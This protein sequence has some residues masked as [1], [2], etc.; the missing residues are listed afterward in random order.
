[1]MNKKIALP[2]FLALAVVV[3]IM[4]GIKINREARF[5]K[6]FSFNYHPDK[7]QTILNFISANYVDTIDANKIGEEGYEQIMQQL[8]PH[9]NYI[10]AKDYNMVNEPLQ[11]NFKGVGIEFFVVNDTVMVINTISGG[12]AEKAGVKNGDKII[13]IEDSII[14]GKKI[15]SEKIFKKLRGESDT[16]VRI[17]VLR[18]PNHQLLN[19][20]IIRGE[21]DVKSVDAA[22]M[23][24]AEVG[25]I[26]INSFGQKTYIEF[27]ENLDRMLNKEGMKKLVIDLRDNG[28]GYLDAATNILDELIDENKTLVYTQGRARSRHD[29][30]C[31]KDGMFEHGQIALLV[32]EGSASASEIVAGALQDWDRASIVGRRTFGKGLV[33]EEYQL[34]DGSAIRITVARYYTPSGRCI[35]KPYGKG[36][37]DYSMEIYKRYKHGEFLHSDSIHFADTVKYFTSKGKVVFGG[38]GIKPDYFVPADTDGI[39]AFSTD[40]LNKGLIQQFAYDMVNSNSFLFNT[41][42]DYKS[43]ATQFSCSP[44]QYLAFIKYAEKHGV[45]NISPKLTNA[46]AP[47]LQNQLKAFI[48]KAK[49][50]VNGYYFI[51]QQQDPALQK[52]LQVL[53]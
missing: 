45:K 51:S 34:K 19:I 9:S 20:N 16:K 44:I 40:C 50:G 32:D 21:V 25:Y 29:Y 35:Q 3:G 42:K 47:Y 33:Q 49:W 27:M 39:N 36:I 18:N 12:P 11:G 1:M 5:N 2:F 4:I 43:F 52:A 53:K 10:T 26:K 41:F 31:T 24:N 38:G 22:F 23:I 48:A 30:K 46:S 7:Y 13:K 17:T 8:D 37:S 15:T 6:P 14:A 28:G